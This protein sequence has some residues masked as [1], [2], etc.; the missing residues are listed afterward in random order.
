MYPTGYRTFVEVEELSKP[1]CGELRPGYFRGVATVQLK[2]LVSIGPDEAYLGENDLQQLVVVRRMVSDL[3]LPLKIVG[4]P[5]VR[6]ADGLMMSS[7]NVE[8]DTEERAQAVTLHAS[9]CHAQALIQQGETS[10]E[11]V[12][13]GVLDVLATAPAVTPDALAIVDADTLV[14]LSR[15]RGPVL[16]A[17]AAWI[18]RV[19]LTDNILIHT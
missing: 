16:I 5:A 19:R 15:L 11:R 17:L 8:L 18:G 7:H 2:L 9:L 10:A 1:L 12:A 14:P 4:F 6:E 13:Q 3:G